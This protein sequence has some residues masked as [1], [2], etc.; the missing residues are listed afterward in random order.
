MRFAK[1]K[2]QQYVCIICLY[3]LFEYVFKIIIQKE[4]IKIMPAPNLTRDMR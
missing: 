3:H 2:L 1:V 4:L